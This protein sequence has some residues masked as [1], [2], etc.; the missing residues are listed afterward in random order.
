MTIYKITEEITK[1][2]KTLFANIS[3]V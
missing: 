2:L 1:L 3:S